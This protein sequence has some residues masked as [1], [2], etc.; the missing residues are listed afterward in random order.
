ML[1]F[2]ISWYLVDN[3]AVRINI[4]NYIQ[5][6]GHTRMQ[7]ATIIILNFYVILKIIKLF[8]AVAKMKKNITSIPSKMSD[9]S[10]LIFVRCS[11]RKPYLSMIC[12]KKIH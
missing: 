12:T 4:A 5:L 1:L 7:T 10:P 8:L 9:F 2:F 6:K 11:K 3:T